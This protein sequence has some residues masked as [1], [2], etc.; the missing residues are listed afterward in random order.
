MVLMTKSQR[1]LDHVEYRTFFVGRPLRFEATFDCLRPGDTQEKENLNIKRA[2][3]GVRVC[4]FMYVNVFSK[5][6]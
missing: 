6:F 5:K 2:L 4:V 1:M 3:C